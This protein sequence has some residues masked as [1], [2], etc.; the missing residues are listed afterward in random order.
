MVVTSNGY[1]VDLTLV[2]NHPLLDPPNTHDQYIGVYLGQKDASIRDNITF[3][4]II[5]TIDTTRLPNFIGTVN[6]GQRIRKLIF[7]QSIQTKAL[8]A[9]YVALEYEGTT[10]LTSTVVLMHNA[11]ILP[12]QTTL[13]VHVG[14]TVTFAVATNLTED[15]LRWRFN[16]VGIHGGKG[17]QSLTLENVQ[18]NQT[19]VYKCFATG[20]G[21]DAKNAIFLLHVV[22]CPAHRWG[23]EC[24]HTCNECLNGGKCDVDSGECVCP[25]GFNGTTC[26]HVLGSNRFGQDG[27]FSCDSSGDDHSPGCRGKLFCLPD[28]FGCTC[29]AGFMGINCTT[30]CNPGTYGAN[31]L[32]ECHCSPLNIC[33]KDTGECIDGTACQ[34]GWTGVNC[35]VR[36][37]PIEE[38]DGDTP[39]PGTKSASSGF[40]SSTIPIVEAT[41][42]ASTSATTPATPTIP[43][44][45]VPSYAISSFNYTKVNNNE[46]IT[47]VCVVTGL[48]PPTSEN[49]SVSN[50]AGADEGIIFLGTNVTESTRTSW[51]EVTV[52]LDEAPQNF[53]CLLRKPDGE[54]VSK[55][56]AV[57]VYGK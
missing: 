19:G 13:T 57:S 41:T 24:E 7:E 38:V 5:R 56:L 25:P 35:Q 32:Q 50:T 15:D 51:Y 14:E 36:T 45:P 21:W 49:I 42:Q 34:E 20:K 30:E 40:T 12:E 52:S 26:E 8:G 37:S 27:S 46:P 2:T 43:P 1:I 28:P 55:D 18:L 3:D 54:S 48:P 9:F 39:I 6:E 23:S 4:R 31:C 47:M 16:L 33:T 44:Q 53:T 11:P 29:A 10:R 17:K 22:R